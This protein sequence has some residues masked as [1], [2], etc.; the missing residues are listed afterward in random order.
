MKIT[1]K[2]AS[3]SKIELPL[4]SFENSVDEDSSSFRFSAYGVVNIE[5][6]LVKPEYQDPDS[7][8]NRAIKLANSN[9]PK[10]SVTTM[11]Q[12]ELGLIYEA[13]ETLSKGR[14]QFSDVLSKYR[15]D[16]INLETRL[17]TPK[18]PN[19]IV[20]D[21][22]ASARR[23]L[24]GMKEELKEAYKDHCEHLRNLRS[25]KAVNDLVE[26]ASYSLDAKG[27]FLKLCIGFVLVES[28]INGSIIGHVSA[29]GYG[30]SVPQSFTMALVNVV[31]AFLV[32]GVFARYLNHKDQRKRL[33]AGMGIFI[34]LA[35]NFLAQYYFAQKID[36]T[37][38]SFG[39][40]EK[41]KF[42]IIGLDYSTSIIFLAFA[43]AV[44]LFTSVKAYFSDERYPRYG[45]LDREARHSYAEYA[46]L[47]SKA[48]DLI[49]SAYETNDKRL[50]GLQNTY[51]SWLFAYNE[52]PAR[53]G[54]HVSRYVDWR[55][56]VILKCQLR[57]SAFRDLNRSIRTTDVPSY[58]DREV[59]FLEDRSFDLPLAKQDVLDKARGELSRIENLV[60]DLLNEKL[61]FVI[62]LEESFYKFI[63]ELERQADCEMIDQIA[64]GQLFD[65]AESQKTG[66][67]S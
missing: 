11:T 64:A 60:S 29:G 43:V 26:S 33:K 55:E 34:C 54:D 22:K 12:E 18:D 19:H 62:E 51:R 50:N 36:A 23:K 49:K 63:E 59:T 46:E 28:I 5:A 53:V 6:V 17:T 10:S 15:E 57:I 41:L 1:S 47:K 32:G 24:L 20:Q 45:G 25:F 56:N 65:R 52:I 67:L 44:F 31:S 27:A 4:V 38:A 8:K 42:G 40:I 58:F 61:N 9:E 35:C 7:L 13:N 39:E 30:G 16:M 14:A 66:E 3:K 48:M 2:A 21:N 37:T